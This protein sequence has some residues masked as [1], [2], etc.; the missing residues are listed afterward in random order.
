MKKNELIAKMVEKNGLTKKDNEA[1]L[2]AF[3]ES[4][5]EALKGGDKVSLIGFGAFEVRNRAARKGVNPKTGEPMTIKAS[6][7]PTFKAGKS[8]KDM[9]V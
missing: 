3:M 6:K 8:F 9:I 2:N 7:N 4:V 1:C 5:C